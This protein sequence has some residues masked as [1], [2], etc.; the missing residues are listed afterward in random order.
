VRTHRGLGAGLQAHL[1]DAPEHLRRFTGLVRVPQVQLGSF[2]ASHAAVVGD[3]GADSAGRDLEVAV[4]KCAVGKPCETD[5][6]ATVS[7][8]RR[9]SLLAMPAG[10]NTKQ[11]GS[12]AGGIAIVNL[13]APWA[14]RPG[15]GDKQD[16]TALVRAD[17]GTVV[18]VPWPNGKPADTRETTVSLSHE[19]THNIYQNAAQIAT[20]TCRLLGPYCTCGELDLVLIVIPIAYLLRHIINKRTGSQKRSI[21]TI[22]TRQEVPCRYVLRLM[23]PVPYS[24]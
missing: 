24:V 17:G 15:A 5:A 11:Q 20:P 12:S 16:S 23:Y 6:H 7:L 3:G 18:V 22:T 21:H 4:G 2:G 9:R 19:R 1:G 10:D 8:H 13:I 14:V